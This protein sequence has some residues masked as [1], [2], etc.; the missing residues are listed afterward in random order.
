[1][2][3]NFTPFEIESRRAELAKDGKLLELKHTYNK[4]YPEIADK[5]TSDLWSELNLAFIT[6]EDNPMAW[7]RIHICAALAKNKKN[8]LD[9]G[10]GSGIVEELITQQNSKVRISGIDI[11]K[12][13]VQIIKKKM[14]WGDFRVGSILYLPYKDSQ[15]DCVL[16]LEILEHIQPYNTFRALGEVLRV[17]K[18]GGK[19][20]ISVPLNEGLEE[21]VK[22]NRNLNA[23]VRAYTPDLI[24]GELELAG[25]H[26]I[27]ERYLYAFHSFYEIKSV[28]A[29]LL[30]KKYKPNNII[31]VC[32]KS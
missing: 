26:P 8:I 12:S 1:M 18:K 28:I 3:K 27:T 13:S 32:Q 30:K 14:P 9:I 15:F 7:E 29:K 23:H 20:I 25:L 11:A 10:F 4:D 17:L 31:L 19:F 21:L 5:N 2:I 6:Q 22:E 24:K 16:A